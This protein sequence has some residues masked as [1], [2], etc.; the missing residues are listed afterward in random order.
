MDNGPAGSANFAMQIQKYGEVL[1]DMIEK[2][3]LRRDDFS[4]VK[5]E[6]FIK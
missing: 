1:G 2:S 3:T 4:F 6:Y 5:S